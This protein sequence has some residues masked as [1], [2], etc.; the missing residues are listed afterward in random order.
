LLNKSNLALFVC[1]VFIIRHYRKSEWGACVSEGSG[2]KQ[3][4]RLV[5]PESNTHA[6]QKPAKMLPFPLISRPTLPDLFRLRLISE[7][8]QSKRFNLSVVAV[9]FTHSEPGKHKQS[10]N[11]ANIGKE[12]SH[13]GMD[14][15][16]QGFFFP[17]LHVEAPG[18]KRINNSCS[19]HST[20]RCRNWLC[21]L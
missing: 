17:Q 18:S 21:Y 3:S 9:V 16:Q 13:H 6:V 1:I 7:S 4:L 15:I 5:Q 19:L 10:L 14:I 8:S 20:R 12:N 11:E 2:G